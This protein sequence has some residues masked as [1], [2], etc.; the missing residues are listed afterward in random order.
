MNR[1]QSPRSKSPH[2]PTRLS[3]PSQS[4]HTLGASLSPRKPASGVP[5]RQRILTLVRGDLTMAGHSSVSFADLTDLKHTLR[6]GHNPLERRPRRDSVTSVT[7]VDSQNPAYIRSPQTQKFATDV[8]PRVSRQFL[9]Q[10]GRLRLV[11]HPGEV[12]L[13]GNGLSNSGRRIKTSLTKDGRRLPSVGGSS[14]FVGVQCA[15][16]TM[17][18]R[19]TKE[20]RAVM[21]LQK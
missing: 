17:I 1:I 16:P 6:S 11:I 15:P 2:S 21:L 3:T 13:R 12:T 9:F 8:P 4:A 7:S 5:P 18:D 20:T 14:T 19:S 10:K